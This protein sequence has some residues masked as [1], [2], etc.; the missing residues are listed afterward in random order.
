M[1]E[2]REPFL[3]ARERKG[4]VGSSGTEARPLCLYNLTEKRNG[5]RE[6]SY[7]ERER[8]STRAGCRRR[9]ECSSR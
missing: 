5:E 2:R 4:V 8:E 9:R 1:R 6:R 7:T 3:V